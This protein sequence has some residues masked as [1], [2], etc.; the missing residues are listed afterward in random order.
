MIKISVHEPF[1]T[2]LEVTIKEFGE[3]NGFDYLEAQGFIKT[4]VKLGVCK[5]VGSRKVEGQKGKPTNVYMLPIALHVNIY[6]ET[7]KTEA[8]A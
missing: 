4:L 6:Q 3:A 7:A 2:G 8:A 5:Q 1:D